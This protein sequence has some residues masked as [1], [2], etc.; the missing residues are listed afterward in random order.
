MVGPSFSGKTYL[1]LKLLSR[2][3][4]RD[5]YINT[6]SPPEQYSNSKLKTKEIT[7]EI[8][9]LSEYEKT[10]VVFDDILVSPNSRH[11][12][13]FLIRGRHNDINIYYL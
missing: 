4:N 7:E 6:K 13:H 8:K 12:D 1:M 9:P 5:V 10:V 11:V 3:P 2:I